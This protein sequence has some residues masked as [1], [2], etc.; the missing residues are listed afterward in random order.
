MLKLLLDFVGSYDYPTDFISIDA[1]LRDSHIKGMALTGSFVLRAQ[2]GADPSFIAAA[3]G[4]NPRFKDLPANLPKQDR[5]GIKFKKGIAEI[6]I[7]LYVA[8]TSNTWQAGIAG[9]LKAKKWG[10]TVEASLSFDTL[11][12][13]DPVFFYLDAK[14]SGTLKK[15]SSTLMELGVKLALKG[16]GYWILDGSAKFKVL[17]L[18]KTI[19]FHDE[20]GDLQ[21]E[22]GQV[23]VGTLVQA[24]L[25]KPE[26]WT[27]QLPRGGEQLVTFRRV[28]LEDEVLAHPMGDVTVRQ[29]VVP[30]KLRI[31]RFGAARPAG[32]RTFG[33]TEVKV[34]PDTRTP[35]YVRDHFASAQF[36]D[37][38]HEQKLAAESFEKVPIGRALRLR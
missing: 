27:A 19:P 15:G 11:F 28:E 36:L 30:L 35:S 22:Q 2:G 29:T 23:L 1:R 24:A 34:G 16:P 31:D 25:A 8:R 9:F 3:G 14:L 5:L 37:L 38:T 12:E 20:W 7:E 32:E 6:R 26:N 10:F 18:S 33:I 4:F 21:T 13:E 17:F